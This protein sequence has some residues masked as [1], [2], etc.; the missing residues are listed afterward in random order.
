MEANDDKI[1]VMNIG[2]NEHIAAI[3]SY[4][5]KKKDGTRVRLQ[6]TSEERD[7]GVILTPDFKFSTQSAHAA[8]KANQVLGMLKHTFVS[9]DVELWAALYRTYIRPHLEFAV[10]SWN[11][12]LRRDIDALEKV[13]RRVTRVPTALR[14]MDYESRLER[15][16]LTSLETR[17][18]RGDLIQGDQNKYAILFFNFILLYV[19]RLSR[20][21]YFY[22]VELKGIVFVKKKFY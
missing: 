1:K 7:R 8:S 21:I 6:N 14:D 4:T 9:R 12:F 16:G 11:P 5:L 22:K 17:R 13:Q 19:V 18:Q 2:S 20:I 10:S 15:M 3:R